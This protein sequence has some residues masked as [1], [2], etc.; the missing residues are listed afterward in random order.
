M[1][2]AFILGLG[3]SLHCIGMCGPIAM[4]VPGSGNS[5][6]NQLGKTLAY[7]L[8]RITT[9]GILGAI[10][11][12][13]GQGLFIAGWQQNISIIFGLL[14][15]ISVLFPTILKKWK[16]D[17]FLFTGLNKIK[18]TLFPLIK[19]QSAGG[20]YLVGLIN[21]LLPCGLIYVA[22]AG[23][24]LTGSAFIAFQYMVIF[25]SGTA[26]IM[27]A[28]SMTSGLLVKQFKHKLVK[29]F[30][31]IV[32]TMGLIFVLRGLNLG[33]PYLSPKM[34]PQKIECCHK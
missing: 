13:F 6:A 20:S 17:S 26:F 31:V 23:A 4:L 16:P 7:N 22:I 19:K 32:F 8:G 1:W 21:G 2:T 15:L 3:G 14:I 29:V 24:M 9:Y 34:E 5:S 28:L 10:F 27:I 30:P 18:N 33:V 11:G 25:G 12:W